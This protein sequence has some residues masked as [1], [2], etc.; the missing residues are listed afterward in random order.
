MNVKEAAFADD[1]S[2]GWHFEQCQTGFSNCLTVLPI[3][4]FEFDVS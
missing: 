4:E 2:V 1:F 3:T